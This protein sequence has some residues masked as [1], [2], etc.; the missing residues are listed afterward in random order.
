MSRPFQEPG[1][2]ALAMLGPMDAPAA[3]PQLA[4]IRAAIGAATVIATGRTPG[5]PPAAS[6]QQAASQLPAAA[7]PGTPGAP[8]MPAGVAAVP[9]A[10]APPAGFPELSFADAAQVVGRLFAPQSP[11]ATSP[12][13]SSTGAL[14]DTATSGALAPGGSPDDDLDVGKIRADF[15][16]LSTRVN[17]HPLAWLD[18]AATTQKPRAVI[19]AMSRYYAEYNSNVHRG[20]HTLAERATQAF[21]EGRAAVQ[22]LLRARRVEEIVFV[23]GA[24]EGINLIAQ[25]YGRRNVAAGDEI[26]LTELEHHS[27]IVPWQLLAREVGARLRVAP[28]DDSGQVRLEAYEALFNRRTRIVAISQASNALGTVLPVAAMAAIARRHGVPVLVDGAQSIPHMPVDVQSLGCDFLVFSGHKLFGP[29]GIGCVYGRRELLDAMPPWQGGGNMIADVTFEET[30]YNEVP[31]RFEAGT[32]SIAEVVGLRAAIDYLEQ[33]GPDRAA[34][35]EQRLLERLTRGLRELPGVRL[36]GT[37]RERVSL[38]SFVVEGIRNETIGKAADDAGIAVRVGH[39][40]AQ[41]ALRRFGVEAT[42]RPSLAF[43]NTE[44]EVDR[45]LGVIRDLRR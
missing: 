28:L 14:A 19:D 11:G 26:L 23:R 40:C 6:P 32:P 37:A 42:V 22:R 39:H 16:I 38:V 18:N 15:P 34:R 36:I 2:A 5:A 45:F 9:V 10:A 29:T 21:A 33:I 3:A 7:G 4:A 27:N 17:G 13:V 41:P 12:G 31:Q 30:K 20:A 1:F 25:S 43:Y 35:R 24:T 44:E 8:G